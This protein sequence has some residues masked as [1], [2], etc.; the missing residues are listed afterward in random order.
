MAKSLPDFV[1]IGATKA[2]T[3]W[4]TQNLQAHP[5][6]FMPDPEL[7]YFSRCHDQGE[8][9]YQAQFAGAAP[10]QLIGEKSASYLP[11]PEAPARL[12]ALLPGARL[13]AQLRNPIERAYSDYC[14]HFR[15]GQV[16]RN[17]AR[18]LD[19]G[20]TTVPRLLE[21]G[22]YFQ[23]LSAFLRLFPRAQLT[24]IL[25]DDI[26]RDPL[27]VFRSVCAHIGVEPEADAALLGRR[28]KNKDAAV[29]PPL[30]KRLLA[31]LKPA[32]QPFREQ[33]AFRAA[34][35]LI[36]RRLDYPELTP[37]LRQ[38]L[39]DYYRADVEALKQLLERD[40][41][42]WLAAPQPEAAGEPKLAA[43]PA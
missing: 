28:I 21:D 32:V 35:S 4:L 2:A 24:V 14:M 17:L 13:V 6:I 37:R 42:H 3:T 1:I 31:P 38:Q 29:V 18:Y 20:R 36:A 16:G 19:A 23:H 12:R 40:L 25:Y 33:R 5:Q 22:L 26:R 43:R 9:W 27:P 11:H 7:H 10:G 41:G 34:R 39:A 8:A 30:A 15:R